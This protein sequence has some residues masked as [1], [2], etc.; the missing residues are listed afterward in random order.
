M[1][2]DLGGH[3]GPAPSNTSSGMRGAHIRPAKASADQVSPP[4]RQPTPPPPVSASTQTNR[5]CTAAA[6]HCLVPLGGRGAGNRL[7]GGGN[8]PP[9]LP[10]TPALRPLQRHSHTPTPPQPRFQPRV[11]DP[12]PLSQSPV[13]ALLLLGHCPQSPP[14]VQAT[15]AGGVRGQNKYLHLKSV[16]NSGPL[17][18]TSFLRPRK[19]LL[20]WVGG[21]VGRGCTGPPK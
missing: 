18:D 12:Q 6:G 21:C 17:W 14:P 2:H 15:P 3:F 4:F 11:T 10:Q 19:S 7:K 13:T 1:D 9:P 20:M 5:L 16:P 8:P